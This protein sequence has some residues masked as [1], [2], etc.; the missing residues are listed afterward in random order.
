[1]LLVCM[2]TV[3]NMSRSQFG[4]MLSGIRLL[5]GVEA[6]DYTFPI[7][8]EGDIVNGDACVVIRMAGKD[9]L[10]RINRVFEVYRGKCIFDLEIESEFESA[11]QQDISLEIPILFCVPPGTPEDVVRS[12][13]SGLEAVL[14]VKEVD[15]VKFSL[16]SGN[17]WQFMI[18]VESRD[19]IPAVL[20]ELSQYRIPDQSGSQ[21]HYIENLGLQIFDAHVYFGGYEEVPWP[22]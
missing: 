10:D 7:P 11:L 20:A 2:F 22:E 14:G 6:I 15:L 1:M 9:I 8:A 18:V 3:R 13:I 17:R 19:V 5:A 4:A 16:T 21:A 12:S